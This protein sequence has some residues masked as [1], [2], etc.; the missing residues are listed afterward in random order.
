MMRTFIPVFFTT[1]GTIGHNRRFAYLIELM[2]P[3]VPI[4]VDS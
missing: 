3:V 4:V 1:A 2:R